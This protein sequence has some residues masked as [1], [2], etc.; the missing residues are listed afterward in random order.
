MSYGDVEEELNIHFKYIDNTQYDIIQNCVFV[1][2][3]RQNECELIK[4]ICNTFL[5]ITPRPL[6]E[7]KDLRICT[8]DGSGVQVVEKEETEDNE[9]IAGATAMTL[10]DAEQVRAANN[11]EQDAAAADDDDDGEDNK[12][13]VEAVIGQ[14]R[15]RMSVNQHIVSETL[16]K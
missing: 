10:T 5:P 7:R 1:L 2:Q 4:T 11:G 14:E 15:Q 9:A 16:N 6:M 12:D 3:H 8:D 13:K